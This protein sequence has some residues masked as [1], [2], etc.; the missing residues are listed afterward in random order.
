ME[1]NGY[2]Y[3][4]HQRDFLFSRTRPAENVRHLWE[5][6]SAVTA[7]PARIRIAVEA[8]AL[9]ADFEKVHRLAYTAWG[10]DSAGVHR[11]LDNADIG[12]LFNA[13]V[14]DEEGQRQTEYTVFTMKKIEKCLVQKEATGRSLLEAA[15]NLVKPGLY[16]ARNVA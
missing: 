10:L 3:L 8:L 7:E 1:V 2:Y 14:L 9:G 5:F 12:V 4:T 13:D 11:F 6:D 15:A 16:I